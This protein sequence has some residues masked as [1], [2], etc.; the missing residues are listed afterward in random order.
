MGVEALKKTYEIDVRLKVAVESDCPM[1]A[2]DKVI[3]YLQKGPFKV[4]DWGFTNSIYP[5]LKKGR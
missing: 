5:A 4:L 3:G 1:R 2:A